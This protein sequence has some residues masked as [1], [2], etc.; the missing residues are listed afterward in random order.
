MGR[1]AI[2]SQSQNPILWEIILGF[3]QQPTPLLKPT[4]RTFT[5]KSFAKALASLIPQ[6]L[7][8]PHLR[9]TI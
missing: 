8:L 5:L 9:K 7:T 4:K 2:Q 6:N 3:S 1:P